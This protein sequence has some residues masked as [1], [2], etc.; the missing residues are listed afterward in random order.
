MWHV[1]IISCSDNSL[2]T[3][4]TTDIPRRIKEHNSGKGGSYTRARRPV[5][6]AHK[7][8]CPTRSIALKREFR[9]K[10]LARDAKLALIKF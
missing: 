10:C 4:I 8:T 5:K 1:Y 9:I 7:E 6:L 3:G 2:Y